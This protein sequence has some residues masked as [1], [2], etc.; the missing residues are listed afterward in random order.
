MDPPQEG[1]EDVNVMGG[2]VARLG[3][4]EGGVV[5]PGAQ[6]ELMEQ[7]GLGEG[8]RVVD[9]QVRLFIYHDAEE[10]ADSQD[11]LPPGIDEPSL[12]GLP[13]SYTPHPRPHAGATPPTQGDT[14]NPP[15]FAASEAAQ[16]V[17]GVASAQRTRS[18]ILQQPSPVAGVVGEAPPGYFGA[19]VPSGEGPVGG[20]PPYSQG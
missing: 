19:P 1:D 12:P 17:G 2:M 20:L 13:T 4:G 15:S 14:D 8:T 6:A 11:D 7:L 16:A 5:R 18:A 3:L 9:L 10:E